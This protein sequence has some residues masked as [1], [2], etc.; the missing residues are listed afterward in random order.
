MLWPLEL[1]VK[2]TIGLTITIII[3]ATI[4]AVMCKR[5]PLGVFLTSTAVSIVAFVP[6]CS[7]IMTVVDSL[8]FGEFEYQSP[9][10]MDDKRAERYLPLQ[11]QEITIHKMANGFRAKYRISEEELRK[12]VDGLWDRY[13]ED[14]AVKQSEF[15]YGSKVKPDEVDAAF[16]EMGWGRLERPI[17]YSSPVEADGGS[18]TFYFDRAT[19]MVY[20][21][22]GYW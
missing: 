20:Q 8:R 16:S 9:A 14:S 11:A 13:S 22:A 17:Q 1:P 15:L 4:V 19:D 7:A 21:T 12:F 3:L 2:I 5:N 6:S 10:E 18:S